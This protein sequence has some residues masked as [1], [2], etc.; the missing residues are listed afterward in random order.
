M[1]T[2]L[3]QRSRTNKP[4]SKD[5]TTPTTAR[6]SN[7][8]LAGIERIRLAFHHRFPQ[9]N[10]PALSLALEIVI[11]RTITEFESNPALLVAE[12]EEFERRYLSHKRQTQK[13]MEQK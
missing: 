3:D 11:N 12:I 2:P 4:V 7:T 8:T 9:H 6:I 13:E 5:G 1:S 10:Y